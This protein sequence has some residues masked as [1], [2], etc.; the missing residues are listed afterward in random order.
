MSAADKLPGPRC[1]TAVRDGA[2]QDPALA[3]GKVWDLSAWIGEWVVIEWG[4]E[5]TDK[6]YY[7]FFASE[8]A[9]T[10]GFDATTVSASAGT[11]VNT[12]PRWIKIGD[13]RHVMVERD[14]PWIRVQPKAGTARVYVGNADGSARK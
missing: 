8:A 9:A 1:G 6:L 14:R 7:G 3:G 2:F 11:K 4:D 10:T 5:A 12:A 13:E